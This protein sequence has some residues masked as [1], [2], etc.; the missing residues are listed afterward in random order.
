MQFRFA[1]EGLEND[2]YWALFQPDAPVEVCSSIPGFDV[3]LFVETN[4][5]SLLGIMLGRTSIGKEL[6]LGE[7]F[8]SG[9]AVL[10]RTMNRWLK[11]SEYSVLPGIE[12][13]PDQRTRTNGVKE[14]L[15]FPEE[16]SAGFSAS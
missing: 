11:I 1:D 15:P 4:V 5:V 3:D 10:S 14:S 7:L 6:E 9:D 2:I 8:L 12:M 16:L 13:L